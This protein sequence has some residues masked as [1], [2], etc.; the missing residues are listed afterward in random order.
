MRPNRVSKS[1]VL[2]DRVLC[3]VRLVHGFPRAP[4]TGRV[5]RQIVQNLQYQ[6]SELRRLG[7]AQVVTGLWKREICVVTIRMSAL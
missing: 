1:V 7:I 6:E 4:E 2:Y 5:E 3:V